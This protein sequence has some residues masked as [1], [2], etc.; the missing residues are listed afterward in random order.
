VSSTYA[1]ET[2]SADPFDAAFMAAAGFLASYSGTTLA[3]YKI[4]LRGWFQ[5]C[6]RHD[7]PVLEARRPHIELYVRSLEEGA[8]RPGKHQGCPYARP[9]IGRRLSTVACF[10]K[11]CDEEDLIIKNPAAHVRRPKADRESTTLGLDR[12]ELGAFLVQAGLSSPRD[13]ALAVLLAMNGLRVSEACGANIEGLASGRGHRTLTVLR[14]GGHHELIPL[15]P[16]TGRA[17]DLA[18]EER[19]EGPILLRK[20]G[21]RLD[22]TGAYRI[23]KRLAKKAGITHRVSP[24]SIRHA[25]VT[26]VLDAGVDIRDAQFFAGHADPRT[27]IFYDRN[28]K[29]LD[30]HPT[31]IL[32]AFVAGASGGGR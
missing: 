20:D 24:H 28:R 13:H 10:Y 9:T 2:P 6:A 8:D 32:A 17:I 7:L 30:R 21:G 3:G 4:D 5:F 31:Y 26:A 16:R 1:L 19:S 22:R 11:W 15:A 25:A 27:T 12:N 14:K 18:V 23:V 29:N